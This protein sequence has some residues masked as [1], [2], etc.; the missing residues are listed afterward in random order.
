M[1]GF[2]P[3]RMRSENFKS[4]CDKSLFSPFRFF[5]DLHQPFTRNGFHGSYIVLLICLYGTMKPYL[6]CFNVISGALEP[7]VAAESHM[8]LQEDPLNPYWFLE[9]DDS[10]NQAVKLRSRHR[11]PSHHVCSPRCA[12]MCFVFVCARVWVRVCLSAH[13]ALFPVCERV[14]AGICVC[15][16]VSREP[17]WI[18][19]LAELQR[20]NDPLSS[21]THTYTHI[22][23]GR[24]ND[25]HLWGQHSMTT[26]KWG[27]N[28]GW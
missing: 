6:W 17:W 26:A 1:Q 8:D 24:K 15:V 16:C 20:E 23:A 18:M 14:C 22:Q 13:V 7:S 3:N 25:S 9:V 11:L 2:L 27:E 10:E 19:F 21:H 12:R 4:F 5:P 28:D